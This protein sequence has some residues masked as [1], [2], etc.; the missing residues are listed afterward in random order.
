[1]NLTADIRGRVSKEDSKTAV[2]KAIGF[3]CVSLG[4]STVQLHD[5]PGSRRA[6]KFSGDW[7]L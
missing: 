6:C 7:F 3:V 2:M 4:S 1:M 5:N